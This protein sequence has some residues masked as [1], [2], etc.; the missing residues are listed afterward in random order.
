MRLTDSGA[1]GIADD[2]NARALVKHRERELKKGR[3]RFTNQRALEQW[4]GASGSTRMVY[5]WPF[6]QTLLNDLYVG[7]EREED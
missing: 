7:L 2:P 3:S 1:V 5:R 6:V 4:S